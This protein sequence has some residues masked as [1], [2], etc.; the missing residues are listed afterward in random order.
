MY[1][2]EVEKLTFSPT[3]ANSIHYD[4]NYKHMKMLEE[5]FGLGR[6]KFESIIVFTEHGELKTEMPDNVIYSTELV[7][8]VRSHKILKIDYDVLDL[9][10]NKLEEYMLDNSRENIRRHR[11]HVRIIKSRR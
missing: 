9:P 6:E 11:K 5:I 2:S 4:K 10:A 7:K 1:R 8:L 3:S